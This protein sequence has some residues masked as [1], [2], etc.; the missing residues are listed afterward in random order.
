MDL[1]I[2]CMALP[3][4]PPG[5]TFA[6]PLK[7]LHWMPPTEAGKHPSWTPQADAWRE[8]PYRKGRL[9][10]NLCKQ[11]GVSLDKVNRIAAF[12]F[13][14]GANNGLRELLRNK[15]D[16]ERLDALFSVD[17]LHPNLRPVPL[18]EGPRARYAAWDVEMEPFAD[19]ATAAAFGERLAVFTCSNV[20]APSK[21]NAKTAD[22]LRDLSL[23]V[24]LRTVDAKLPFSPP[25]LPAGKFPTSPSS[26]KAKES[27]GQRG[28]S[29]WWYAG[30][31]AAAHVT[32]GKIVTA[33]LWRDFLV[34]VW[35]PSTAGQPSSPSSPS[36]PVA[37]L[38]VSGGGTK[39]GAPKTHGAATVAGAI[40]LAGAAGGLLGFAFGKR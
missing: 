20:A 29:V 15:E 35:S 23:D 1:V 10:P 38:P 31:D 21:V 25:L 32:Q 16:R 14:A 27:T 24:N 4:P 36:G 37:L 12:G 26:P 28:F 7:V 6:E 17:G 8:P 22:A 40:G 13:S 30:T 11:F 9:L 33:D 2:S 5:V 3:K 34:W 39:A 19:F 18:G